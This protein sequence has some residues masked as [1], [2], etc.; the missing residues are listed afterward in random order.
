LA[1]KGTYR[2]ALQLNRAGGGLDAV[3]WVSVD[4][5]VRGVVPSE[6]PSRWPMEALRAQAVA[7]RSYALSSLG[8]GGSFDLYD[9]TRSQEYH[10][11]AAETARTDQ[12]VLDTTLEV[13]ADRSN[14]AHTYFF[15]TSGGHTENVENIFGGPPIYYLRGVPDPYDAPAP[16]HTWRL[17]LSQGAIDSALSGLVKGTLEQVRI[18]KTGASPRVLSAVLVGSNGNTTVDG[19]TLQSR[20]GLKDRW[21]TFRKVDPDAARRYRR[22]WAPS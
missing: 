20:F 17:T 4:D 10:G 11:V 8:G 21:V 14:V 15:S 7:A 6:I 18:T 22:P 9:D 1:G 3:D 13:V 12:A 5:Y 19:A 2:G 16:N